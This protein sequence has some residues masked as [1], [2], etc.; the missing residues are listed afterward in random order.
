MAKKG[1]R[2]KGNLEAMKKVITVICE[3]KMRYPKAANTFQV[4]ESL[5]SM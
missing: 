5:K 2:F 3:K 1:K 4:S